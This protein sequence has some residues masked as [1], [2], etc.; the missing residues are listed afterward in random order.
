[1]EIDVQSGDDGCWLIRLRGDLRSEAGPAIEQELHPLLGERGAALV[2][3]LSEMPSVDS[4]GLSH[5]ISLATHARLSQSR[6][7][8]VNP[9]PFVAGVF[10]M[11]KLD[12]WFDL[13]EDAAEARRRLRED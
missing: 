1:M 6:V 3:D 7:I 13:A 11:T 4:G 10:N 8:L 9:T 5:L 2:V 12:T